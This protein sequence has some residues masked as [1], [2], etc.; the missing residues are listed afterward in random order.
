LADQTFASQQADP[1]SKQLLQRVF[2]LRARRVVGIRSAG[3]LDW[4][5]E[6]GARP[7]LLDSVERGLLAQRATWDD[8]TDPL[9][10]SFVRTML[11]W[12]W[13]QADVQEVLR[14]AHRLDDNADM[15]GLKQ[16]FFDTVSAWLSGARFKD[17]ASVSGL[18]LD[19][20]LGIH[21][22]VVSYVLQT[23]VEQGVAILA[24]LLEGQGRLLAPAVTAFP[25]HLRFGVPTAA[26]RVLAGVGVRHRSAVVEL[27]NAFGT[28]VDDRRTLIA[29]ARRGLH[30]NAAAWQGRLGALVYNNTLWDLSSTIGDGS[31]EE[32]E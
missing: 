6:T 28:A 4:I 10:S 29:A 17:I 20:L 13:E 18:D 11:E 24:K 7:R 32:A 21:G 25:E 16:T 31:E 5:R 9:D 27:G 2:E 22:R 19:E 14:E 8:I 23:V 12:A 26:A 15:S 30:L 3:R 1:T